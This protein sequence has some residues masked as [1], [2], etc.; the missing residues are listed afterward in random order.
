MAAI[1]QKKSPI[2]PNHTEKGASMIIRR[3]LYLE[4]LIERKGNGLIKIVTGI[5]RCGKS[6][7]LNNLFIEHLRTERVD[8]AHII[9]LSLEGVANRKYRKP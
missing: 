5:R 8:D 2:T 7:L 4:K 6:F 9:R 1:K 3:D